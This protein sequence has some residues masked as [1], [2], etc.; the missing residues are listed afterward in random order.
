MTAIVNSDSM[1]GFQKLQKEQRQTIARRR[2]L[3][4]LGDRVKFQHD[5]LIHYGNVTGVSFGR[6][7]RIDVETADAEVFQNI[8]N[9]EPVE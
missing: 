8:A 1:R 3:P 4:N 9:W 7:G 6:C 2:A 5:G